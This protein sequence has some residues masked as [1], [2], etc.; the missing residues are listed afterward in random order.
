MGLTLCDNI[1]IYTADSTVGKIEKITK[2]NLV[3][4]IV[5][6]DGVSRDFT[7]TKM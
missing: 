7:I 5:F 6:V 3:V 4:C 2:W 1:D